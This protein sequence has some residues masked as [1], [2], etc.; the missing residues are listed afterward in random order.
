MTT[1]N[2]SFLSIIRPT[3]LRCA[4]GPRAWPP[5]QYVWDPPRSQLN[6]HTECLRK[7]KSSPSSV[8]T[9]IASW[10]ARDYRLNMWRWTGTRSGSRLTQNVFE[11]PELRAARLRCSSMTLLCNAAATQTRH[12]RWPIRFSRQGSNC[13]T[14]T[15][16]ANADTVLGVWETRLAGSTCRRVRQWRDTTLEERRRKEYEIELILIV[17]VSCKNYPT[18]FPSWSTIS[19]VVCYTLSSGFIRQIDAY[20]QPE[21]GTPGAQ[22]F[23]RGHITF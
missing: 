7:P 11:L 18:L 15:G 6:Q 2:L 5:C 4:R 9:T 22:N 19:P 8:Y 17:L 13:L 1:L 23:R 16:A 20:G 10:V 3:S 21:G 12:G 14:S